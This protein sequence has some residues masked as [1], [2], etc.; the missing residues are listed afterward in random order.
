MRVSQKQPKQMVRMLRY[1]V[2]R[3]MRQFRKSSLKRRAQQE[4]SKSARCRGP[5]S[6]W[7]HMVLQVMFLAIRELAPER[8]HH[9]AWLSRT[10][11]CSTQGR[12]AGF[13][14]LGPDSQRNSGGLASSDQAELSLRQDRED[15]TRK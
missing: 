11:N 1:I 14:V 7:R 4:P 15:S 9:D 6:N 2:F 8:N 10:T 5:E 3:E 12:R 13:S